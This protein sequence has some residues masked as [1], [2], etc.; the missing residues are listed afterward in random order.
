MYDLDIFVFRS[1]KI[2]YVQLHFIW[3]CSVYTIILTAQGFSFVE[4]LR[5]IKLMFSSFQVSVVYSYSCSQ[6]S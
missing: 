3:V 5:S 2:G 6:F 1:N 4:I